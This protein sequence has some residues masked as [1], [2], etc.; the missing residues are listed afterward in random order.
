MAADV[1]HAVGK[2]PAQHGPDPLLDV[3]DGQGLDP[4][5]PDLDPLEQRATPVITR[6]ADGE[7][8]VEVDVRLD[9]GR[10]DERPSGVE[11][12]A[13]LAGSLGC[14]DNP[15]ATNGDIAEGVRARQ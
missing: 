7:Y 8:G 10:R 13:P 11:G 2:L 9:E 5:A 1:E 14:I 15:S 6:L 12:L 3:L 4:L